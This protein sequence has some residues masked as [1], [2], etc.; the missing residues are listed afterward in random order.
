MTRHHIGNI[1]QFPEG[2]GRPVTVNNVSIAVFNLD[3]TLKAL[4]DNCPH[5]NLPLNKAGTDDFGVVRG[6]VDADNCK[7][8]CPWHR[9][10]FD[11][12]T[13]YNPVLDFQIP[14]Y[15]VTV[16][17]EGEVYLEM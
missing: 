13:G 8:Q 12:E 2:E 4:H 15:N 17:D 10:E 11:A 9:M 3:G 7:I 6:E 1:E 14:T 5:K 16:T